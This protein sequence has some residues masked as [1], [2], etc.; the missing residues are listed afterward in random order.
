PRRRMPLHWSP[1]PPSLPE[2]I[3]DPLA[4][5]EKCMVCFRSREVA[6]A[7][8]PASADR[9]KVRDIALEVVRRGAG[10]PILA[11]HGMQ[12]IDPA[13]RFLDLLARRA[14]IIAPSHPGF[15]NS[16]R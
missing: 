16:P 11:L 9:L 2:N 10:Q 15:G 3:Y 7:D 6:M 13:A 14:E 8:A 1:P 5:G 4:E 12:P